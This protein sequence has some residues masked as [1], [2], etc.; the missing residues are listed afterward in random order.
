VTLTGTGSAF[1]AVI[2]QVVVYD[3]LYTTI[4]HAQITGSPGMGIVNY[5]I[6]VPYTSS[7]TG[8]QEGVVV[9]YHDNGGLSSGNY[10]AVVVKVLIGG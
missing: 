9:A 4:G 10:S 1:E 3:H 5:T 2:G 6:K 8:A 7:F